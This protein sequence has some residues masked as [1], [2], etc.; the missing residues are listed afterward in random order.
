[1]KQTQLPP[2]D[3]DNAEFL[4]AL[5]LIQNTNR[6]VFLTGKAGTGKS[7][8][9][10]YICAHTKKR[11]VV[12][13]PT[14]IAAI[15]VGGMTLHSFFQIPFKP[16][17][18][19]D[20]D[21]SASR[22]RK[23]IRFTREKVKLIKDLELIII[24]EISMVRCDIIDYID[25]VLRH[26][27]GNNREPFGGKQLLFVGDVF[28]LEPVIKSDMAEILRRHYRQMFFFNAH[29][30]ERLGLIPIE[31]KKVYRQTNAPFVAMLDRIRL[32]HPSRD[33][34]AALD[35]RVNPNVDER[36]NST[37]TIT[38]ATRRD[39]VDSINEAH[40][41]ALDTPEYAF[42]GTIEGTFPDNDLPTNKELVLKQGAQVIF[43]RN[44]ADNRWVNGTL[45][46]VSAVDDENIEVTLEDGSSHKL[47]PEMWE[48]IQYTYD[49]KE[50]KVV[51]KQL[52]SFT[53]YPIKPA[54]A[55]TVHKSQG[56]T[57][58]NVVIDFTG[59]AFTGGQAY[60]A[61]SRCTSLE[62]ITLTHRLAE[63]DIFVNPAIVQFSRQFNDRH[64]I[65]EALTRAKARGLYSQAVR[66]LDEDRFAEAVDHFAE[67][68]KLHNVIAE[69]YFKRFV[70]SKL[71]RFKRFKETIKE[72]DEIIAKQDK[73]LKQLALEFTA[74]GD[75]ALGR[76]DLVGEPAMTYGGH[77][78]PTLDAITIKSAMANY[79]KALRIYPQ[80]IEAMTGK[81]HL[82]VAVGEDK[83]AEDALR[84]ALK[85]NPKCFDALMALAALR[86]SQNDIATA[87]KTLK[88]A[89][90]HHRKR[91]EPHEAL[92][93]IYEK[94][95]LDDLAEEHADIARRL[96]QSN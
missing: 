12:L 20:P 33:D 31:L 8:F 61:L 27:S 6:S 16:L 32:G 93:A 35:A 56:L 95:G 37:F 10:K 25:R 22:I 13:A 24:D 15:N 44:D 69:P 11:H 85:I 52:G 76:G 55:L 40:M 18:P 96:R 75:N 57:F 46:Q 49:E 54:W 65:D 73:T 4:S 47:E 70:T 79:D 41:S 84:Q 36:D 63:R 34:M 1:M 48:N 53:Q 38:L 71:N 89:V 9:L 50:K 72:R 42:E 77:A 26:F 60:V 87:V 64:A 81:A 45:G 39:T 19:D 17:L 62:G 83:R 94:V 2:I 86:E 14:G 88:R 29:T 7:T 91:P 28:Q 59:G 80:C 5:N 43:I 21:Y 3:L 58:N 82:L 67:A 23:T 78:Y 74:M 90:R 92:A 51:E 66:A 68:M 30:F